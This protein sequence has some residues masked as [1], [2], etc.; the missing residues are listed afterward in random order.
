MDL[1]G[2]RFIIATVKRNFEASMD[3]PLPYDRPDWFGR[4]V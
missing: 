1:I 4:T 2:P 3:V